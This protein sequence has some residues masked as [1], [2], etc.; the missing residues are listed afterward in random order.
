[1]ADLPLFLYL[2]HQLGRLCEVTGT[3]PVA[4]GQLLAELLGPAGAQ[5]LSRPP[6]WASQVADDHTPVE[7][8][9]AFNERDRPALRLLGEA[10]PPAPGPG[11]NLAAAH[12]FV[13]TQAVRFGLPLARYA[14]VRDVFAAVEPFGYALWQSVVL[15]PA[16]PPEFKV[17]FKPEVQGVGVAP[18]LVTEAMGRLGLARSCRAVLERGARPGELGRADRLTFFALD[19]HS[20][21]HARTK[22]YLSHHGARAQDLVRAAGIV[23]G[24]DPAEIIAC[25][26]ITGGGTKVFAGRPLVGSY[27]VLATTDRPVGYSVYIPIRDYVGDDEE[28]A[29]RVSTLLDRYGLDSS[30]FYRAVAA[31]SR[32]ALRDGVGLI[33]HVSLR[34]GPPRPGVTVYLSAEA[35]QV[36]PPRSRQ[37]AARNLAG[38]ICPPG[39]G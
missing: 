37:P 20:G 26:A 25:C 27:T 39:G 30:Q 10:L 1:M 9:V 35:Y 33:A 8:S 4:A 22:V 18:D 28:A 11:P 19:L 23:E 31:V 32:R 34:L 7:Y 2:N 15:L 6:S 24:I 36:G 29:D 21:P 5:P 14:Q 38:R 16:R 13:E 17:Y 3:D 12:R